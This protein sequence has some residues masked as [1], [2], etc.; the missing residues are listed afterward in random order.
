MLGLRLLLHRVRALGA[1]ENV[2]VARPA[3]VVFGS[4][5]AW[6]GGTTKLFLHVKHFDHVTDSLLFNL[7]FESHPTVLEI[8][9]Q[10]IGESVQMYI[11][12]R[13]NK[14]KLWQYMYIMA[15]VNQSVC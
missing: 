9:K 13:K 12:L 10:S 8:W 5:C 6:R 15:I 1:A 2:V 7:S 3:N 4:R 14:H 11:D